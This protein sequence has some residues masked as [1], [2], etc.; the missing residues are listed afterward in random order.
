LRNF[1]NFLELA[2]LNQTKLDLKKDIGDMGRELIS[3]QQKFK[4]L[5]LEKE[6]AE[7]REA[8]K[9][10]VLQQMEE[11]IRNLTKLINYFQKLNENQTNS[12]TCYAC[13]NTSLVNQ[14]HRYSSDALP[15]SSINEKRLSF[16]ADTETPFVIRF[17]SNELISESLDESNH[18]CSPSSGAP[19][20][21]S[22]DQGC[23]IMKPKVDDFSHS[24]IVNCKSKCKQHRK[25]KLFKQKISHSV[26]VIK[27]LQTMDIPFDL[28]SKVDQC[29][30]ELLLRRQN[31]QEEHEKYKLAMSANDN[32]NSADSSTSN[33]QTSGQEE[34]KDHCELKSEEQEKSIFK[35]DSSTS[36]PI[37]DDKSRD[38]QAINKQFLLSDAHSDIS[39][40]LDSNYESDYSQSQKK[41][42]TNMETFAELDLKSMQV[43]EINFARPKSKKPN[44]SDDSDAT[45]NE[46]QMEELVTS[47]SN[48]T[49]SSID[50]NNRIICLLKQGVIANNDKTITKTNTSPR[51][52]LNLSLKIDNST[53][54][55]NQN[56]EPMLT[57][58]VIQLDEEEMDQDEQ[59]NQQLSRS[60][61]RQIS[62]GY[63]SSN[64][65]LSA[66]SMTNEQPNVNPF[67]KTIISSI[68]PITTTMTAT[69]THSNLHKHMACSSETSN[70][71][72]E[73]NNIQI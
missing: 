17:S 3:K 13:P 43:E 22:S 63:C 5:M 20:T 45:V 37:N 50:L 15:T 10:E 73:E 14:K 62:D 67:F 65:P 64:T 2:E 68:S 4:Q 36:L 49:T 61:K 48:M 52:S 47:A 16:S 7:A 55:K 38:E 70:E 42:E 34:M 31:L 25:N 57:P 72:K 29:L 19:S 11:F 23:Y 60:F 40:C 18:F 24:Q 9:D 32:T 58:K 8:K 51:A 33:N 12:V 44:N 46:S 26:E 53:G 59:D 21:F 1:N 27:L 30:N 6:Q 54:K 41:R 39:S 71:N 28:Y 35:S 69:S 66:S 56:D